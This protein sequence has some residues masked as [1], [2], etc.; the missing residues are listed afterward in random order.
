MNVCLEAYVCDGIMTGCQHELRRFV[1]EK[2][3]VIS[4]SWGKKS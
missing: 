1:K 2:D 4:C 3:T